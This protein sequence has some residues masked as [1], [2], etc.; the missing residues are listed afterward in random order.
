MPQDAKTT[1]AQSSDIKSRTFLQYRYD[2]KKKAIAELEV[3]GWLQERLQK[4]NPGKPV[5]VRKSGGDRFLWFLRKGGISRE[6]DYVATVDGKD[7]E[8]EFQ[9][10]KKQDL[11]FYDFKVSKVAKKDKKSGKR[12]PLEGKK[13]LLVDWAGPRYALIEPRWIFE[14]GEY[15]MVPAWRS[16]AFRVPFA[17]VD[18]VLTIDASLKPVCDT[19][20]A[21][22]D[23]LEFQ[24]DWIDIS[25]EALS[26]EL[27]QV[28]DE[29]GLVSVVPK[30]RESFFRI[31]FIL[32][33]LNKSPKN[34]N[35]WLVYLMTWVSSDLS[36]AGMSKIVYCID[37]L[38]SKVDMK[39]NEVAIVQKTVASLLLRVQS[40]AKPDGSFQ[41][42]VNH[43]PLDETRCAL[44]AINLL[45]DLMQDMIYYYPN[46][47]FKPVRKIFE[48]VRDVNLT[49]AIIKDESPDECA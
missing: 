3:L 46:V 32:D 43:A 1:Y 28:V 12:E 10:G 36:L 27:Q 44:F 17:R 2:M 45:E 34:A 19:I 23:I 38:Y 26:S 4:D 33:H 24:H 8:I 5:L 29:D 40:Y 20:D 42:T 9:Y 49:R 7:I 18:K 15:D 37:F 31:C 48:N 22:N 11:Q 25:R 30:D 16:Y 39:P 14:N 6:S 41:S 35:L 47:E 13:F 21:K